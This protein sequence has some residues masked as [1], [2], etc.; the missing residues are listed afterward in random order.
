M[1]ETLH[2]TTQHNVDGLSNE[3]S[4]AQ[5]QAQ[6]QL[7][8]TLFR[9]SAMLAAELESHDFAEHAVETIVN[10]IP[11]VDKAVLWFFDRMEKCLRLAAVYG[12]PHVPALD[13]ALQDQI[14]L[15]FYEGYV[16][17]TVA[18]RKPRL[19]IGS[20]AFLEHLRVLDAENETIVGQLA[21]ELP[22]TLR[23]IC[24]PLYLGSIPVGAL[25]LVYTTDAAMPTEDN[26]PLLQAFADQLAVVFRNAQIYAEMSAQHRRLQAFDAVVRAITN[27]VDIQHMLEQALSVT[28]YVVGAENGMILLNDDGIAEVAVSYQLPSRAFAPGTRFAV[29]GLPYTEVI[30]SGQP[31]VQPLRPQH[32]WRA[33]LPGHIEAIAML[34]LLAG[35]TVVGV[36]VIALQ[37]GN[38]TRLDWA[39]LL[40]I[41]NQIGIAVANYRLYN[42]SQRERRQLAGVIASI[43]EGVII[44]DRVG[45]LVLSNQAAETLLGQR[46]EAGMSVQDLSRLL[47]MRTI[48]GHP[49]GDEETPFARSLRGD[50]YQNY[51]LSITI[52]AGFELFISCSGAPLL[53]EDTI[54]GAVVVIRDVT[55]YKRYDA[56][57]DEFVAVAAHELRAPLAAIKGYTDLLVQRTMQDQKASDRDR[58]GIVM[59]SRQ[60]EH[61]VRLIDNLLDVSRLDTGQLELHLQRVDL[62]GLIEASIDRISIG[63]ANHEFGFN[64]PSALEIV[65]DPLRIQ[66][67]FTNLLSNAA[68]Y[69]A[70]GTAITVDVWRERCT[71]EQGMLRALASSDECVIVAV[72]DQGVGMSPEV[73]SKVFDRYYRANTVTATSGLG[74]GVYLSREIVLRHGGRIWV[75]SVPGQGTTFYVLLPINPGESTSLS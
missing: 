57:R 20:D 36:L 60:I 45:C 41:G 3:P 6:N 18:V 56:V 66:Q 46:L 62:I 16:G 54:D 47:A 71:S 70:A 59:L 51:E 43:A 25:E 9:T 32:P 68:R 44:C 34:P 11:E 50:V 26:L 12:V 39:A 55:A 29:E 52:G 2:P 8:L 67:V 15:Q 28:L 21:T 7:L 31:S 75:D 74:L 5:L 23:I 24:L 72:R 69:S 53:A 64:G 40:A 49:L 65:C 48:D 17:E 37:S 42:A 27:A 14:A 61:L 22:P 13:A 10:T 19:L 38:E 63:D 1:E 33:W 4:L 30:R 35:G 73:Q 58:R